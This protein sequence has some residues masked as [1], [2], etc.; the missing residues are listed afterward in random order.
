MLITCDQMELRQE[1][2]AR[3]ILHQLS[4]KDGHYDTIREQKSLQ[5]IL[6]HLQYLHTAIMHS[7]PQ[8]F[9]DYAIWANTL[10][11]N[12]G[13][14]P[15]TMLHVLDAMQYVLADSLDI[16]CRK[17]AL[18][19]L[20]TTRQALSSGQKCGHIL[21]ED[22]P[23][24]RLSR[25]YLDLLLQGKRS[26]ASSLI[27]HEVATG[28][29]IEDIYLQV[30]EPVLKEVGY[31]W[32]T[33]QISVAQE[34]FCTAAT[35]QIMS[36]LYPQIFAH[37][38]HGRRFMAIAVG[39]E[40]HELGIRMVAD[41]MEIQG[42]ET[43]YCGANTPQ[44]SVL[45]TIEEFQPQVLGISATM[46]YHIGNV[47]QLIESIHQTFPQDAPQLMVGGYPFIIDQDLWHR[48]GA[49]GF[50]PDARQAVAVASKLAAN[51]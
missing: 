33:N 32:Q 12:L 11:D 38:K 1:E 28:T 16:D 42:W 44:T 48:I 15:Q 35:Q 19:I 30:F 47:Q 13:F 17:Q 23:L 36:M 2:L 3:E 43:Y 27:L 4:S 51:A 37:A 10:F 14:N 25:S 50:A 18:E 29:T 8:L 7:S 24:F 26:Q 41:F 40:L 31:L 45:K 9:S 46:T 39:T 34:H 22:A 49:D 6:F 20:E 21:T 5:D